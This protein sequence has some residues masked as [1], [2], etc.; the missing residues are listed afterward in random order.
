MVYLLVFAIAAN[1]SIINAQC[2]DRYQSEVFTEIEE[3]FDILYYSTTDSEGEPIDLYLDI[4]SPAGDTVSR[5][6]TVIMA[7]GGAFVAGDRKSPDIVAFCEKLALKGYVAVSMQYR[8]EQNQINLLFEEAMVKAVMRSVQDGYQVL[9]FLIADANG[10][11]SYGIDPDQIFAGGAS[12]GGFVT[13]HL[14]YMDPSDPLPAA[15]SGYIDDIGGIDGEGGGLDFEANLKGVIN[16]AGAMGVEGGI[17]EGDAPLVSFHATGDGTVPYTSGVPLGIPTLPTVYG[18]SLMHTNAMDVGVPSTLFTY[19]NDN[20]PPYN[21][22][23]GFGPENEV[24][25]E[26]H[27]RISDFLYELIECPLI[28]TMAVDT[29]N[30]DTIV[31]VVN[32]TITVIDTMVV[33]VN[34]T[35]T[36]IDTMAVVVNDTITVIDTMVVVVNDTITVIDSLNVGL[37]LLN[38]SDIKLFPNPAYDRVQ[39]NLPKDQGEIEWILTDQ[40]GKVIREGYSTQSNFIIPR[41]AIASGLYF[42]R[43]RGE[44]WQSGKKLIFK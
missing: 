39:V 42:L 8:L 11:N 37:S 14:A 33:V 18:S 23:G 13:N 12:A 10:E 27:G 1:F 5:R 19:D 28:D 4:Y 25:T 15:W 2:G 26:M 20:H 43:L 17:Q 6:P 3:N 30:I 38:S 41:S 35:I 7:F 24:I 22:F 9:N 44:D 29:M 34:D 21:G 31:V 32:D 40:S 36:V 16:M